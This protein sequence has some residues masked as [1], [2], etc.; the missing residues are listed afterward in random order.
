[1]TYLYVSND[2]SVQ[3]D[4]SNRQHH[5]TIP[6]RASPHLNPPC[7][8]PRV[9]RFR[10]CSVLQCVALLCRYRSVLQCVAVCCS[11]LQCVTVTNILP[12]CL[13]VSDR[14]GQGSFAKEP[15]QKAWNLSRAICLCSEHDF[16][17]K[18]CCFVVQKRNQDFF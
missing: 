9:L 6:N 4:H 15:C 13:H 10:C 7:S 2:S 11:V 16:L 5:Q 1:M 18:M 3:S 14:A 17:A 8:R 12:V